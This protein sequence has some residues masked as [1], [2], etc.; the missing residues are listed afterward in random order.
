MFVF[1]YKEHQW[2]PRCNFGNTDLQSWSA[3]PTLHIFSHLAIQDEWLSTHHRTRR[4]C[5]KFLAFSIQDSVTS[6]SLHIFSFPS[7]FRSD[8]WHTP[9]LFSASAAGRFLRPQWWTQHLPAPP[10][11]RLQRFE[12]PHW[13]F[14]TSPE[15]NHVESLKLL[16]KKNANQLGEFEATLGRLKG[17]NPKAPKISSFASLFWE[18][19]KTGH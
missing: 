1:I 4:V 13:V 5:L 15:A 14:A 9:F 12:P 6:V 2:T 8:W 11:A 10:A 16:N 17:K 3:S 19:F 7:W 18:F